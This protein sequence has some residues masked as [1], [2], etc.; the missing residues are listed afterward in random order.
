MKTSAKPLVNPWHLV[1]SVILIM[2]AFQGNNVKLFFLITGF[3]ALLLGFSN[4]RIFSH[5]RVDALALW[6]E[7]V[8]MGF[9]AFKSFSAGRIILSWALTGL[10]VLYSYQGIKR[11]GLK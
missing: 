5:P 9:A 6:C 2:I 1:A 3:L 8:C 10:V 4:S 7:A 11:S